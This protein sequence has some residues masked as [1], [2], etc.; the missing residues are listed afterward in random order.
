MRENVTFKKD[1]PSSGDLLTISHQ[2]IIQNYQV[3][4]HQVQEH[5]VTLFRGQAIKK[6]ASK[7]ISNHMALPFHTS[8]AAEQAQVCVHSRL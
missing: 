3:D 5:Q 7:L 4:S 6:K 8:N 2:T 1:N